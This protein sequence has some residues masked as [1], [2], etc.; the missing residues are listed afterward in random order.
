MILVQKLTA[1]LSPISMT[2]QPA[3]GPAPDSS[4]VDCP[5]ANGPES[6]T[7]AQS[8][9]C[10]AASLPVLTPGA[11]PPG[12]EATE[13]SAVHRPCGPY[14]VIWLRHPARQTSP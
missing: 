2:R 8:W 6:L 12:C 13:R 9:P 10:S 11:L 5:A 7:S 4:V 3:N 14:A 1:T